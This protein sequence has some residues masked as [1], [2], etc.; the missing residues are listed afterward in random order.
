LVAQPDT[1]ESAL[2]IVDQ[3]VRSAAVDIVVVDSVA[4]LVPRAE[5]EGEMGDS[6]GSASTLNEPSLC[7]KSPAIS[8]SPAVQWFS[9]I[10]C[11][12]SVSRMAIQKRQLAAIEVLRL[13]SFRHPP[14]SN[15]EE[16]QKNLATASRKVA[17]ISRS[18]LPHRV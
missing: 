6:Y 17:K 12:K 3:M 5:I 15:P 9:S 4:A 2:E 18:T 16:V 1:G 14:D 8:A 13:C 10:N 11:K 7:V